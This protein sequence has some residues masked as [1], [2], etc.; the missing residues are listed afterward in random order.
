MNKKKM[1]A[2][3]LIFVTCILPG[4][5]ALLQAQDPD[6][7]PSES[8]WP[9]QGWAKAKPSGVGL[10]EKVLAAFDAD[11]ASGK[12]SLVDSFAV[13]RCGNSVFEK[14][15]SHDYGTIYAKRLRC[16]GR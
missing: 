16:M 13:I 4:Q 3:I 9:T 14:A 11:L 15:Y 7:R 6:S 8:K 12:Y 10:D 1:T 2:A 5:V